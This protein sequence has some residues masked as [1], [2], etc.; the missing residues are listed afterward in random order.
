LTLRELRYILISMLAARK[1]PKPGATRLR[2]PKRTRE[3]LLQAAFREVYRSGFQGAS[4]DAILAAA[5]GHL[6]LEWE[7]SRLLAEFGM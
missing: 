6:F 4:L 5:G 2:D 7:T 1:N 3:R